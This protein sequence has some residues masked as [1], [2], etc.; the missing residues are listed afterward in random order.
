MLPVEIKGHGTSKDTFAFLDD[1]STITLISKK[2]S[3]QLRL[4]GSTIHI[5]VRGITDHAPISMKCEKVSFEVSGLHN[6]FKINNAIAVSDLSFPSQ[7]LSR[8]LVRYIAKTESIFLRHFE[9]AQAEIIIGQ[10]NWPLLCASETR[11][12]SGSSLGISLTPLGWVLHGSMG[13]RAL[14]AG[15]QSKFN[16]LQGQI[17]KCQCDTSRLEQLIDRHFRVE[18]L[19]VS[20]KTKSNARLERSW[21]IL[22]STTRR[23][24]NSWETG[25]IWKEQMT[26]KVNSHATAIKRLWSLE[27]KLDRDEKYARLYY[28]EMERLIKNGYAKE[29]RDHGNKS[30]IWYLPHFG[31]CSASKPGKIRI[32]FDAAAKTGG[33]SL[34]D[35]L[36]S[37]PDLGNSL[38]GILLRFRQYAVAIKGDIHDMY[39]RVGVREQDRGA[40]R[41]LWRGADRKAYPRTYEMT[42]LIF[43]ATSSP[44]SALYVRNANAREFQSEKAE[45]AR[46]IIKNSYIDDYLIS[47]KSAEE[48]H[49]LVNDVIAINARGNFHMH[50]W[51]TNVSRSLRDVPIE[52]RAQ[53]DASTRLCDESW[54]RVLGLRWHPRCDTLVCAVNCDRVDQALI[55]GMRKPSKRELL[56]IIMSVFDPLGLICPYTMKSKILMQRV[57][58]SGIA[59]DEVIRDEENSIWVVWLKSLN[60]IKECRVPRCLTPKGDKYT[61]VELHAFCDASLQAYAS[62]IYIRFARVNAPAH[63]SLVL[64]RARVAPLKPL[65]VPR[66]ELQAALLGARLIKTAEAELDI[67]ITKR[68]LWS[69]SITVLRWITTEP[70]TRHMYVTHRLGEISELT[71]CSEWRWVPTSANPAD[72]A[73]RSEGDARKN[74]ALWFE[75]PEFL[76]QSESSWPISEALTRTAKQTIDKM[77]TLPARVCIVR[78]NHSDLPITGRFLGWRGLLAVARRVKSFVN[79]W[80]GQI[81]DEEREESERAAEFWLREIQAQSFSSEL[82]AARRSAPMPKNSCLGKLQPFLDKIG[83][84]RAMGR[85]TKFNNVEFN[86]NPIILEGAHPIT[87]LL[88]R[89]YHR[90]FHHGSNETVVNELRQKY[91]VTGVRQ[92]LRSISYNCL[93]C[94]LLRAKPRIPLMAPL[95]AG[96]LAYGQRPFTHCGVDYFGP[97]SVKIGRRREKRW[98]VLFTCLTTRAVH[99]ELASTLSA[100]SAIMALQRL[101]ARRGCPSVLYSDNGTNFRGAC[102]ELATEIRRMDTEKQHMYALR[103]GMKW[104]FNPPDAPHMGGAWE[105]LVRSIKVALRVILKEQAPSEETLYTLL[106][107][108]EHCVNSRPLTHVSIDPRDN[109]ALTPNHF[110]IGASS[111]EVRL[112]R[113]DPKNVCLR[114]QWRIAQ[115]FADAFW[116]RWLREYLPT[117]IPRPKWLASTMPPAVGDIVLIIDFHAPRNVWKRGQI[118]EVF[119]GADGAIRVARVRTDQGELTRPIHKLIILFSEK[120]VQN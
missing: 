111:G 28:N 75:G 27:R 4:N 101:A 42:R 15:A 46:T 97:M 38:I 94:K 95:P 90:R 103:N 68:V 76:K 93:T 85:V 78:V 9:S 26:P 14:G 102:T 2:L 44:C 69:D 89:E 33:L 56:S 35:Q 79:R 39:M 82:L 74:N 67:K 22:E 86:N 65:S 54:E 73:T 120:E 51:T 12:V 37:G 41:F 113:V 20:E 24:E 55:R 62:A 8:E 98:G 70:R 104:V 60:D 52:A 45:A 61:S 53:P 49:V 116:H 29:A 92:A 84:L 1:G 72:C 11:A 81:S 5:N 30:R 23:I 34:N 77:E 25:L 57:W 17:N 43:G 83:L 112:D 48:A 64:A 119:K 7:S 71:Q 107:E 13:S 16:K 63:T 47:C 18:N 21:K 117:L 10:D 80:R 109:E 96:R 105:R 40:L 114:K 3:T 66:L 32:V 115:A 6:D 91:Y 19:G 87:K 118:I 108:A 58:R 99:I 88:L 36:E 50:G 59:W 100:S 110:L 31:V 106:T